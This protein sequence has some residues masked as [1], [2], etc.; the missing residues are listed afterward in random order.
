M[1]KEEIEATLGTHALDIPLSYKN[2]KYLGFELNQGGSNINMFNSAFE[3]AQEILDH[4][5]ENSKHLI[6]VGSYFGYSQ[7]KL[8]H[9]VIRS[10]KNCGVTITKPYEYW[11]VK[12]DPDEPSCRTFIAFKIK[13]EQL[14]EILWG[15]LAIEI[16]IR[17]RLACLV[18]IAAPEVGIL[19]HPYDDRG[20][21]IIGSNTTRLKSLYS[22]FNPWLLNYRRQEMDE[23]F[24]NH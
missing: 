23:N 18:H 2:K 13:P 24:S 1:L 12:V 21:T 10:F 5:F 8:R 6:V 19:A 9:S 4:A 22:E 17:P 11:S 15:V 16:G 3:R 20:M 14:K 7:K